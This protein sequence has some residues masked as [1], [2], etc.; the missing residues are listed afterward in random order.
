MIITKALGQVE[1]AETDNPNGAFE[2]I[3]S[4]TTLDRDGEVVDGKAFEP[5]PTHIPFDIDHGM[6]VVT[7]VGSGEPYYAKDGTLRVK[8]TFASTPLGQEVRTL[9]SEGHVRSTSVAFMAADRQKDEKGVTHVKT[10]ELLN[11]TF[12]PVPANREAVVLSSKAFAAVLDEKVGARNSKTDTEQ[13]QGAHDAMV[14][15]GATCAAKSVTDDDVMTKAISGSY[16]DRERAVYDAVN[17]AYGDSQSDVWAYCVATF[18]TDVVF[19]VS[20]GDSIGT[21]R[22][23]YTIADDGTATLGTPEKVVVTEVVTT[24]SDT[25][26]STSAAADT[27]AAKATAESTAKDADATEMDRKARESLAQIAA[28]LAV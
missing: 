11:G 19:R 16:E 6:S 14:S 26:A 24:V 9:V 5:L 25:G 3:L 17:S 22:A 18:D 10:A 2:V 8:G 12:T 7:T 15:L 27:A 20:G 23:D 13:I 4:A 28:Q 1:T 21:W